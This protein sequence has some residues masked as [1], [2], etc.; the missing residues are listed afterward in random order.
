[1]AITGNEN[2]LC[3]NAGQ[4]GDAIKVKTSTTRMVGFNELCGT[5]TGQHGKAFA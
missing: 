4:R 5:L 3:A 1:M 2:G